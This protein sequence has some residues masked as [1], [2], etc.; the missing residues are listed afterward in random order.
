M[1]SNVCLPQPVNG[2]QLV[3]SEQSCSFTVLRWWEGEGRGGEGR[4]KGGGGGRGGGEGG[5]G[6]GRGGGNGGEGEGGG[7]WEEHLIQSNG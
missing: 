4:G 7:E 1:F 6:E 2:A 5:G 3:L